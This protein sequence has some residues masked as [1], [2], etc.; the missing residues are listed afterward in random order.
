MPGQVQLAAQL[1]RERKWT[2]RRTPWPDMQ[3]FLT[4]QVILADAVSLYQEAMST[5]SIAPLNATTAVL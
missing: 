5:A 2:E 1:D 4:S 3:G